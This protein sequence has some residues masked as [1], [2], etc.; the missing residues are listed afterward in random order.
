MYMCRE[1]LKNSTGRMLAILLISGLHA[2][3]YGKV[4][5]VRARDGGVGKVSFQ[6]VELWL[7]CG[8]R[9]VQ[10]PAASQVPT[11]I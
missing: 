7:S 11:S 2:R 3:E 8:A 10:R 4:V 6:L 1:H 5:H 9:A